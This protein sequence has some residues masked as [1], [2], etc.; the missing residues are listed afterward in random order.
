MKKTVSIEV[1]RVIACF[2]VVCTHIL[3]N[4]RYIDSNPSNLVFFLESFV[5]CAVPVFL[6][7]TGFVLFPL[8]KK[9]ADYICNFIKKIFVPTLIVVILMDYFNPY[10]RNEM[11]F[12]DNFLGGG[13][14]SLKKIIIGILKL[15]A[16]EWTNGFYLWYIFLLAGIYLMLP[17]LSLLCDKSNH[18]KNIRRYIIV[19]TILKNAIIPFLTRIMPVGKDLVFLTWPFDMGIGYILLG[20]E[21]KMI[22]SDIKSS[23]IVLAGIMLYIVST[24]LMYSFTMNFDVA[25]GEFQQLFFTWS[26]LF[27]LFQAIGLFSSIIALKYLSEKRCGVFL[28]LGKISFNIYLIHYPVL[29]WLDCRGIAYKLYNYFPLAIFLIIYIIIN[30]IFDIL[31]GSFI[32]LIKFAIKKVCEN[33]IFLPF[34]WS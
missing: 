21:I 28:Y 16:A 31:I 15:D 33:R 26:D 32:E 12:R 17:I 4:Y 14:I 2:F 9:Y 30:F 8:H 18:N 24:M 7:I 1:L 22:I 20:Y 10:I 29:I 5:R 13:T 25:Q 3:M 11:S 6:M 19:L 23:K 34:R 27:P